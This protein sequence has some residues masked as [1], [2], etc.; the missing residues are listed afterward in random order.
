MHHLLNPAIALMNRLSYGMKFCL[1]SML[2]FLPLTFVSSMLVQQAYHQVSIT[3]HALDNMAFLRQNVDILQNAEV[4][5]DMET[6]YVRLGEGEN[7]NDLQALRENIIDSLGKLPLDINDANAASLIAKR[8]EVLALYQRFAQANAL[9]RS[10]LGSRALIEVISLLDHGTAYAGLPQDKGLRIRQLNNLLVNVIPSIT[11]T[12]GVGRGVGSYAVRTGYLNSG[13]ARE[14]D[15]LSERMQLLRRDYEQSLV[16]IMA[17]ADMSDLHGYAQ[18][19]LE[20]LQQ[21]SDIFENEIILA[22]NLGGSWSEYFSRITSEMDKTYTMSHAMLGVLE[23]MLERRM[24]EDVRSMTMLLVILSLVGLLI[25]YLYAGFYMAT[26]RTITRLSDLMSKVA[27]GDM[28]VQVEVDS[29]DELGMLANEFNDTIERIRELVRAVM[30]TSDDV[31]RQSQQVERISAQ[32]SQ[33]V[34]SQRLQVEQVATA[35]NEMSATSQEVA[36][37]AAMAVSSAEQ[38]NIQALNGRQLVENSV[39]GT[40][41]L[42]DE[43]KNS[44]KVID[45]LAD[46]SRSIRRV[47]EVINGVAEQ[48]NLLALNAAIEAARAGEQGRGFA[49]VADEVRTL[50]RRTRESTEEIETIIDGLQEGVDGAVKAMGSSH[51]MTGATVQSSVQVQEALNNILS[52]LDQIVQQ[53]QQIA[54]AAEQQTAVSQDIDQGIVLISEAGGRTAD[55]AK[56]AEQSSQ[57]MAQMAQDLQ[58]IIKAFRV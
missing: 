8:D 45:K 7:V 57:R 6:V 1:I 35:M 40:R 27:A 51:E 13:T 50:A 14:M 49:V 56:Q 43:I 42:A 52:S 47:L 28:T 46:D 18:A 34:V 23:E 58:R 53:S 37:S 38:V 19:S 20:S 54:A 32:S 12:L 22:G 36:G 33:A 16:P 30:Q 25:I 4:L 2:F 44:V 3:R 26:R 15:E 41:K 48:T 5:R 24:D 39:E 9:D 10:E 11:S 17:D 55:G 29:R 31:H 21:A